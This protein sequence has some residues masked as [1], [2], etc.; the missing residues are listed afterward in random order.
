M[1]VAL[2][3]TILGASNAM[4][5]KI[6]QA[7]LDKSMFKAWTDHQPGA[8]VVDEPAAID[9]GQA[10]F[11]CETNFFKQLEGG[12]V[13]FGNN[14]VYYLWYADL[15]GTQK[16]TFTGTAGLT[17]RVLMNRSEPVEGGDAHGGSYVERKVTIGENGEATLDVSDLDYVHLNCIKVDWGGSGI[18]KSIVLTGTVKPVTGILSMINNGDAEG[19]DLESFPVS[20]DGPNNGGTANERPEIVDGGVSGKCFKV[21]T[22]PEPTET[23][24]TQFYIKSDEVLPQ[25]TKW[26]LNMSIKADRGC[27]VTTSAQAAP[28]EWK[29]NMGIDE[30]GV[31]ENWQDYSW[32]GEIGVD[33][34]QSIAFD[35]NNEGGSAGNASNTFYFDNIE[36][37]VDLGG[38]NPM[39]DIKISA[40]YDVVCVDFGGTTNIASLVKDNGVNTDAGRTVIFDNSSAKVSINDVDQPIISVE[41]RENGNLYIFLDEDAE[42]VETEAD[43]VK[44]AFTNPQAADRRLLFTTGKWEGQAVPDFSGITAEFDETLGEGEIYSYMWGAPA[45]V[46]ITPEANSFNLPAGFN[47]FKITFNQ[48]IQASTVVAKLGK[49]DLAVA[50]ADG[51]ATEFTLTRTATTEI[52]GA[53]DLVISGATGVK[54]ASLKDPIVIKYSYGP[55]SEDAQPETIYASNFSG[56]GDNANGAGWYVNAG[57]ALQPANSGSG[58][59]V[60][61]NQGAFS[62]DLIYIAQRDAEK[63]GVAVYGI[64]DEN[65]LALEG[66]KTYHVTLK[67]CRH[68]RDNVAL[69]VQV[70][71]EDAVNA[72]DGSLVEGATA[73][74]EDFKEITPEKTSK[75][76]INFDLAVTPSE[77]GNFVIRLVPSLKDG[78][79]AGYND[80]VCF[81]D[82]K[83]EFIPDVLGIVETKTLNDAL[84]SAKTVY[85][86]LASNED[87]RYAGED[88][89]ALENLISEVETNKVNY[90]APSV[91]N[92]KAAELE[93]KAKAA[94]DHKT[95]C[96]SYDENI[97][98]AID[99]VLA[100]ENDKFN[101]L[102]TYKDLKEITAKY[103]A[104]GVK[105]NLAGEGE[106]PVWEVNYQFDLLTDNDALANANSELNA[107]VGLGNYIF[108]TVALD[109]DIQQGNCG[110]AV[111]VER[112]RLGARTLKA[113]GVAADDPIFEK[114]EN[115]ISD[116]ETLAAE[117]KGRIKTILYTEMAKQDCTLFDPDEENPEFDDEGN[118]IGKSYDMSVFI[119]NPNVYA[120]NSASGCNESNVPGWTFPAAYSAPGLF[121]AWSGRGVENLPEDCA[122]TT[123]FGNCRMEQTITDLPAGVYTISLCGSDWSNQA[124]VDRTDGTDPHDVN[125]FVYCKTSDT[126][127]VEEGEEEDRELNFA[128]TRTIV[129]GGQYNMDHATTLGYEEVINDETGFVSTADGEFFGIPVTDGKLTIGIHFAGDAQYFFQHARLTL[130]GA[131]GKFDYAGAANDIATGVESA[132]APQVRALQ[133][134]DLNGRRMI[135]ANK[136]LQI[137]KKQMSDGTVRVE[138]VIV[139]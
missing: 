6:Y 79:F 85:E 95:A 113:L 66:G 38:S 80:P 20:Y 107:A 97:K 119:K 93:A 60:M 88:L 14:N 78:S 27:S 28:R 2:M 43:E 105:E 109:A 30:F 136:G 74:A 110:I 108:T 82:V 128:A 45:L 67:A 59:R 1:L 56:D 7:E 29:G 117:I 98:K 65:K 22:H 122:F 19:T 81:G 111:L 124:N 123:W 46:T 72:E 84:A 114:V 15:T 55:V 58:C 103:H 120:L 25:G 100:H 86:E 127:A 135:K 9:D 12:N 116:S 129:Y 94:N 83:V 61:H 41:G 35:L 31:S 57:S 90:T 52:N 69:K 37:G 17:L 39:N 53:V 36:F 132:V 64:D 71:S 26:K 68:D 47:E 62:E 102:D 13:V 32:S 70:L 21:T 49:E 138:K 11:N 87:S 16:I 99:M 112:N 131:A 63:G 54:K 51:V 23:W 48:D 18:V 24:H 104:Q 77:A 115:A 50:P 34:F 134:Y 118:M 126:P 121:T 137:V 8:S 106:D 101:Q 130:K 42:L 73:L 125:G 3:L 40:G 92:A 76:F 91:Y 139:K 133:V 5:Q 89:T 4:A 33:G 10:T 96:D 75:Q 44:V